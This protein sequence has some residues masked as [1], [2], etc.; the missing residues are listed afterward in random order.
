VSEIV[1][2]Q[3]PVVGP[4]ILYS[5][6]KVEVA[7]IKLDRA[8]RKALKGDRVGYFECSWSKLGTPKLGK[9]IVRFKGWA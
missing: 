8:T 3:I 1:Q 4:A 6:D 2:V 9:R 5:K 7:R